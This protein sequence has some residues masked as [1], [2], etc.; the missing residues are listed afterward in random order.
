[1]CV[2]RSYVLYYDVDTKEENLNGQDIVFGLKCDRWGL[3]NNIIKAYSW[4][5]LQHC[6]AAQVNFDG[7]HV[8]GSVHRKA[9]S[10]VVQQDATIYSFYY[11]SAKQLYIFRWYP[12][13]SSGAHANSNY[14][15]WHWSNRICYRPLLWRS[16]YDSS[17]AAD[18]SKCDSIGARCCN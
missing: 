1:M 16:R 14:N 9:M 7:F 8:H 6:Q 15:I 5:S 2:F 3:P 18:G 11:I 17:T 13:P 10:I 12:H 4:S